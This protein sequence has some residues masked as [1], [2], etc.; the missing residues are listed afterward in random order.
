MTVQEYDLLSPLTKERLE[1]RRKERRALERIA[2][3][4]EKL[5]EVDSR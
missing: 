2:D 1:E 4:L 3:A 5:V